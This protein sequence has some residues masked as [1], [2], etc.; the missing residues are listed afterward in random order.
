[1][2]EDVRVDE[3]WFE[4]PDDDH[5]EAAARRREE[6]LRELE[7]KLAQVEQERDYYLLLGRSWEQRWQREAE[8]RI[9]AE[10]ELRRIRRTDD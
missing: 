4:G 10:E 6:R 8:T 2:R 9:A 5:G 3:V 1:M 7:A